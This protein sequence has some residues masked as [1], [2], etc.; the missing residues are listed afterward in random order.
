MTEQPEYE[1]TDPDLEPQPGDDIEV[2]SASTDDPD[3][4]AARAQAP[5]Q[6]PKTLTTDQLQPEEDVTEY[7]PPFEPTRETAA[8][9][10]AED[11]RIGETLDER[12]EQEEPDVP[13][14]A[15]QVPDP[16]QVGD[17]FAPPSEAGQ[18]AP[19]DR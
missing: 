13:R 11:E 3:L 7:E 17:A 6:D 16:E 18:P 14:Q 10:T 2:E 1:R 19:D 8:G 4:E 12:I 15:D 5:R 9:V